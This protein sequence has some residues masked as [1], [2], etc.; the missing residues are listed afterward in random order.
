MKKQVVITAGVC[1]LVAGFALGQKWMQQARVS[2]PFEFV[3]GTTVLPAGTY[4]VSTP[5]GE[6]SN[7]LQFTNTESGVAAF[8]SNTDVSLKAHGYNQTSSL[9]FVL[10]ASGRHVLHQVWITG[11]SHGHDLMHK[12]GIPQPQPR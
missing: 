7:L 6:S 1:L 5:A 12:K 10:D 11:D 8:A 2:V 9:V 4:T 3:V